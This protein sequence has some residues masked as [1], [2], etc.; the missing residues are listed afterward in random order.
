MYNYGRHVGNENGEGKGNLKILMKVC[1][2]GEAW[3]PG[4]MTKKAFLIVVSLM[5][6]GFQGVQAWSKRYIRY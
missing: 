4:V 3:E 5:G 6:T 1:I 2:R